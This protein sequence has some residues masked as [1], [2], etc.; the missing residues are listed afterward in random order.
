MPGA[1]GGSRDPAAKGEQHMGK[2]VTIKFFAF[3]VIIYKNY[4]A[5]VSM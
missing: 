5:G 4:L 3:L 2:D 1:Y